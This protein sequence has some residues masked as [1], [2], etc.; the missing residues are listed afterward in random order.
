MALNIATH[1]MVRT[2]LLLSAVLLASTLPAC[3][4]DAISANKQ[5]LEKQQAQ[6][7]RLQRQVTTLQSQAP[8]YSTAATPPGAC[9]TIVMNEATRKGGDRFDRGD[10]AHA[11]GYYQDAVGACPKNAKAQFNLARTFEALGDKRQA[12]SHYR[13]V[14]DA[15]GADADPEA[16]RP[17]REAVLRLGG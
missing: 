6:L 16:A 7:D 11:L 17:A 4:Q 10:F 3:M 15:S 5:Q 9:D 2:V 14:L 12:L 8:S 13:L 1:R